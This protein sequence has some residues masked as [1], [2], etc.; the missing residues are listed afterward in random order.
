MSDPDPFASL[1]GFGKSK[2]TP[3]PSPT[4]KAAVTAVP[5]V[6]ATPSVVTTDV[7]TAETPAKTTAR[8]P[9]QR[10]P[11][12]E[13]DA[14]A[15]VTEVKAAVR[16]K[17]AAASLPDVAVL[18]EAIVMYYRDALPVSIDT[19]VTDEAVENY[20]K[21][22]GKRA[23]SVSFD[24]KLK[25]LPAHMREVARTLRTAPSELRARPKG[26]VSPRTPTAV[27]VARTVLAFVRGE[28]EPYLEKARDALGP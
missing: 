27:M 6:P 13:V 7:P 14:D 17:S 2:S 18:A 25:L 22:S 10:P 4:A 21:A 26:G 12:D 15:E 3:A 20:A 11:R 5:A 8:R 19:F 9:R 16:R 23:S 1:L 24:E 28:I